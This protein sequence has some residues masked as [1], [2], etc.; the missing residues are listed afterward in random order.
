MD[1]STY[2]A[3]VDILEAEL[4]RT[5]RLAERT[6]P[7]LDIPTCP[8]WKAS[9]LWKHLGMVHRWAAE[10]VESRSDVPVDRSSMDMHLPDGNWAPWLAEGSD[11]LLESLRGVAADQPLWT[12]GEGADAAWWANRL[13]HETLIHNADAALALDP[14]RTAEMP[15]ASVA[16]AGIDERLENLPSSLGWRDP[17]ATPLRELSVHLHATDEGLGEAGEWMVELGGH[18]P[19]LWEHAHDK[20]D[21]AVRGPAAVLLLSMYGRLPGDHPDLEL[22]GDP[23]VWE[24]FR[25]VAAL[26]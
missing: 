6:D 11:L 15:V 24:E 17:D 5:V 19:V 2:T 3:T 23:G 16:A 9:R 7:D 4:T 13:L 25:T 14:D 20:G 21:V 18:P 22:F 26:R 12:W 8:G 10:I 1:E